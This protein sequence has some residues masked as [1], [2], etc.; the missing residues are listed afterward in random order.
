[1]LSKV[2][3]TLFILLLTFSSLWSFSQELNDSIPE[4]AGDSIV[5]SVND[6]IAPQF[7]DPLK[8]NNQ[9]R[10]SLILSTK[11]SLLVDSTSQDTSATKSDAAIEDPVVYSA[12]DS[13]PFFIEKQKLY[14]FGAGQINYQDIELTA[15]YIEVDIATSSIYATSLTDSTGEKI[16]RPFFKQGDQTF[17]A[18]TM[19]YNFKTKKGFIKGVFT[20][21]EGGYLHSTTTK[22]LENEKICI[23]NGKYTTCNAEHPHFHIALRKAIMIP[24]DKILFK[25]ANLV[26]VDVPTPVWIPFGFLPNKKKFTSGVL[27]PEYGEEANRGF[28]LKEG[29]YYFALSDYFD[30]AI[31]GDIYSRG[32]W[33]L[34][35]HTNYKK[36]Y[37]FG[38]N[39]DLKYY[40]NISGEEEFDNY[41]SSKDYS[42]KWSHRQDGKANPTMNFSANVN[43]STTEFDKNHSFS[44]NNYLQNTKTSSISFSKAWAGII[45]FS[46]DARHSQNSQTKAVSLTLPS[47]TLN[48]SR[49]YPF[50]KKVRSG[51]FKWYENI[52][53]EYK[54]KFSN[55]VDIGDSLLFTKEVY[56][57]M[58]NGFQHDIPVSANFKF[59]RYFN[60]TPSVKYQGKLYPNYVEKSWDRTLINNDGSFGGVS[61]DTIQNIRYAHTFDPSVSLSF[62]PTI[63]GMFQYKKGPIKAMRHVVSPS[64]S[65]SY[66]PKIGEENP[67]IWRP[68]PIGPDSLNTEKTYSIFENGVMGRPGTSKESGS[69]NFSLGNNLEMKV[70]SRNDTIEEDVKIKLIE[71]LSFSTRYNMFAE[72]KKW[73]NVSIAGRTTLFK[74]LK[75]NA[76]ATLNPYSLDE[77]GIETNISELKANG[78]LGRISVASFTTG[79]TFKAKKKGKGKSKAKGLGDEEGKEIS[80]EFSDDE[81]NDLKKDVIGGPEH[82]IDFDIPWSF[83]FNYSWHYAKAGLNEKVVTQTL[84]F[85]GDISITSKW[86]IS[87]T[88][89]Y[90]FTK[91]T[92][93]YTTIDIHRDLHCWEARFTWIP[94]GY[95]QSYNFQINVKPGVLQDLKWAKRKSWY[96]NF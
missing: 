82:Y 18:D 63:Y 28:Y 72:E 73:S 59:L 79:Y 92:I 55:S 6:T 86:K 75:L 78:K 90:D 65:M 43:L 29:G 27:F 42:V 40:K 71:S 85:S 48:V 56:R 74:S 54:S 16:G 26:M 47:M 57:H 24:Q 50:R 64:V 36:R 35:T 2:P 80:D 19:R 95:H 52:Q 46:A 8:D 1:M 76:N 22:R 3:Y 13:M 84:R 58:E 12:T 70:K 23:R 15:E 39:V 62:N 31:R 21:Q 10:E 30:F 89:G 34:K 17:R 7:A 88:S 14:L 33:G 66:K 67:E 20:E 37:R 91:K 87:A 61:T 38:G 41:S 69:V 51:D 4:F 94:F 9:F 83:R 45:N 53:V 77:N 5:N 60:A 25:W 96:D 93:S 49:Q 11:D 44:A 68:T 32:T 81:L